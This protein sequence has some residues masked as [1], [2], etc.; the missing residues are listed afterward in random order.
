MRM[1]LALQFKFLV[2]IVATHV[3]ILQILVVPWAC[4]SFGAQN[5]VDDGHMTIG[6][7]RH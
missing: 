6:A 1:R 4:D 2:T 5:P 3:P 7:Q